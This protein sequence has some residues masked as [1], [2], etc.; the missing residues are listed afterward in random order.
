MEKKYYVKVQLDDNSCIIVYPN[1]S[2]LQQISKMSEL[3]H[4][5]TLCEVLKPYID[6]IERIRDVSIRVDEEEMYA[7]M[8]DQWLNLTDYYPI[9]S[10]K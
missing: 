10:A 3:K 7:D 4:F 8:W 1:I 5:R 9:D 2:K 6:N